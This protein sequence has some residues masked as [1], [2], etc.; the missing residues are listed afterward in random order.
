MAL[1]IDAQL[2]D[3]AAGEALSVTV[4]ASP[5]VLD[6]TAET[7]VAVTVQGG[8]TEVEDAT[9]LASGIPVAPDFSISAVGVVSK[10]TVNMASHEE[11]PQDDI[12]V[13]GFTVEEDADGRTLV[14]DTGIEVEGGGLSAETGT[15]TLTGE[16]QS[17]VYESVVQSLHLETASDG[18]TRSISIDVYDDHGEVLPLD[19]QDISVTPDLLG[20]DGALSVDGLEADNLGDAAPTLSDV[21]V[22]GSLESGLDLGGDDLP[23]L[24]HS[25][26]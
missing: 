13:V 10:V 22:E 9:A 2:A 1:A 15:L 8:A 5:D 12:S 24:P 14:G 18:G 21:G 3:P 17:T 19:H 4:A 6:S 23:D 7:G 20:N 26:F 16:A 25:L 11:F